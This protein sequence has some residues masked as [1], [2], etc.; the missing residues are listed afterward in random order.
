MKVLVTGHDG[1]IGCSL[2][3][4]LRAAGPDV[5]GLDAYPFHNMDGKRTRP[6]SMPPRRIFGTSM[7]GPTSRDSMLSFVSLCCPTTRWATSIP[8]T[9]SREITALRYD[10]L[11]WR[12][13][14]SSPGSCPPCHAACIGKGGDGSAGRERSPQ[15]NH[16]VRQI[17]GIR[18]AGYR[19]AGRRPVQRS[20]SP[21][22]DC[23]RGVAPCRSIKIL[24][25]LAH[26]IR[27]ISTS[28]GCTGL[29]VLDG[30]HLLDPDV[31][32]TGY[33]DAIV[34]LSLRRRLT[35]SAHRLYRQRSR[36]D[37]IAPVVIDLAFRRGNGKAKTSP[38]EVQG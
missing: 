22:R 1:Y 38:V 3:P 10:L 5:M 32:A 15:S 33:L 21:Q 2:V 7:C 34:D 11:G 18:G 4:V 9:R 8:R 30:Q 29:D 36:W 26:R 37:V 17:E 14:P 24:E 28:T 19:E 31:L 20:V 25:A 16:R 35:E 6:K 23:V 12:A 27:V 13:R